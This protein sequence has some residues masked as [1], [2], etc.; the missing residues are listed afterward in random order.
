MSS[1]YPP[2]AQYPK[3]PQ[4]GAGDATLPG[5]G[6]PPIRLRMQLGPAIGQA[7]TMVGN[8]LTIG[9]AQDNDVVL[10]D[11]QVSRYHA[12]VI[13]QGDEIIV[14]DLGSTNGTLV[15]GRR[16]VG[17]RVLQPTE[18]IAVGASVFSVEGFPAPTTVGVP[19]YRERV[20]QPSGTPPSSGPPPTS[21]PEG[22]PWLAVGWVGGLLIV[23]IIILTLA[24]LTA[25]LLTRNRVQI[26]A[27]T[28]NVFIQSP[29]AGSQ[30]QVNQPV[31]VNATT[32]DPNGIT[33]AELWVGGNVVDQQQSVVAEGQP[34]FPAT[35][36]WT[37]TVAGSY[38]L[39]VRAYNSLG[40]VSAPTTVMITV[41]GGQAVTDTPTPT[42]PSGTPTPAGPPM[43]ITTTDLNVREGPGQEYPVLGLLPVNTQ[44]EVTGKNSDGSWW[45][46]VYPSGS[47]ERGW[48]YAPFTRPSNTGNV[49]VVETPVPPTPTH[50]PTITPTA[51][52]S[53]TATP[54][55]TLTPTATPTPSP[56]TALAPIVQFGAT[57]TT[58]NPGHC[59]TLQWHIENITA[60][61]LSGGEFSNL[62]VTGPFGSVNVCPAGTTLYI[63]RAETASGPIEQSVTVTVRT[64]QT[65]TLNHI[66]G[67][68]V[69][70]DGEVFTPQPFVGDDS[71]N[72]ALRAFF[73]FDLSSLADAQITSAQLDLSDY[74]LSGDPFEW[75]HPLHVEEVD[76]GPTLEAADYDAASQA[77]LATMSDSVGLDSLIDVSGPVVSRVT[78]GGD[79][80]R[81][82]L[83]FEIATNDDGVNDS[84]NWAGRPAQL[85][86]RYYQ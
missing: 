71:T 36:R 12:R 25:W 17:P 66:G 60:A 61:F 45:Q 33:R 56:T 24:G 3:R 53:P 49:P 14:E 51:T 62:G 42:P 29:V 55:P 80:F 9:R 7:Y 27:T 40:A 65:I 50:T 81:I 22:T 26:T 85:V 16:I 41:V 59:T 13:R 58:I 31:I 63:L 57:E 28:P 69:R 75:L 20:Q 32:S 79:T 64:E 35:L 47:A 43:A 72:Q 67:G 38:T 52:A 78:G 86:V 5:G 1:G 68:W 84:V 70:E 74:D 39:E 6:Q 37:P 10:D 83:R 11:P 4:E 23:V 8:R 21:Q 34:T 54:S 82:R 48:I 46:I 44:V 30:V 18:T 73:A 2:D 76:W 15:N 77:N 19:P